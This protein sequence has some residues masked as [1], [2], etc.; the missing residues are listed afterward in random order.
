MS[1]KPKKGHLFQPG[2][3]YGHNGK[4]GRPKKLSNTE[5]ENATLEDLREY[6]NERADWSE[7]VRVMYE[8]AFVRTNKNGTT[9]SIAWAKFFMAYAVGQPPVKVE[10]EH[11]NKVDMMRLWIEQSVKEKE[12]VVD[13]EVVDD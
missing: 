7:V 8:N 12:I 6:I 1:D 11:I 3:T 2:N 13:A 4:Q 9:G 5:I 10:T